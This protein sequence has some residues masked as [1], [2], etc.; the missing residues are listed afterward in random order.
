M[1]SIILLATVL[2]TLSVSIYANT[3]SAN[4]FVEG[5]K[6]ADY[7]NEGRL[8]NIPNEVIAGMIFMAKSEFY[9]NIDSDEFSLIGSWSSEELELEADI[10]ES[11][12][13][14]IVLIDGDFLYLLET[15]KNNEL[16]R[17]C[18]PM[19]TDG[20]RPRGYRHHEHLRTQ[21]R[22]AY[23]DAKNA[24]LRR[25]YN[26]VRD[27]ARDGSSAAIS[28]TIVTKSPKLGVAAGVVSA[29]HTTVKKIFNW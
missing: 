22:N 9:D 14:I 19:M 16:E 17:C 29:V 11:G 2:V 18:G 10:V 1:K 12:S 8:K 5:D 27:V 3:E 23:D 15:F 24:A 28:T 25:D 26:H 13:Q 7:F 20:H 21:A 6:V 4:V